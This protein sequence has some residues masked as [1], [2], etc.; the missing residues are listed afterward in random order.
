[1]KD[2]LTPL[3]PS[4][5]SS[6]FG[7]ITGCAYSCFIFFKFIEKFIQIPRFWCRSIETR[8]HRYTHA[9]TRSRSHLRTHIHT[10]HG[11]YQW[12]H[13]MQL[14]DESELLRVAVPTWWGCGIALG[15]VYWYT[16][17]TGWL[18]E[19]LFYTNDKF[20]KTVDF[21]KDLGPKPTIT[22][23]VAQKL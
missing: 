11:Q 6:D 23:L 4:K 21:S 17:F 10:P 14:C 3:P 16:T 15:P 2:H 13:C 18:F 8:T 5:N 20:L 12:S 1:M 7:H 9:R 19:K 22:I